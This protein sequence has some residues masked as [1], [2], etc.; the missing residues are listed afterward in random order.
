MSEGL[1]RLGDFELLRE[2][3]RGGMGVVYEARQV[4][5]NRPVALKLLPP[6]LG[7]TPQAVQRFQR[8]AQAAA[9]L[10]H[11]H[12][13]PVYAVGETDGSHYYAMELIDGQP[14][15]AIVRDLKGGG[16]NPLLDVAMTQTAGG[17]QV[18]ASE[19][20]A[21]GATTSSG[22]ATSLSDG[23]SGSR[24]WFEKIA[25]LVADVADV[26]EALHYAHG[27]GIV[28]RDIKP[29]NLLLASDGRL[30]VTDFG[31]AQV[32]QEPGMTVSGSFLGTPAYMSPEQ[33][34]VGR[35]KVDH[36][37]DIYSLGTVLYEMLTL[38]RPFPGEGREQILAGILTKEP[39]APRRIN[40]R[41]S[42]DLETICLK[43]IEKDPDR[44]YASAEAMAQDLR[45]YLG[46]GLIAARRTGVLRRSV[47][48][49][50]RRPVITTATVAVLLVVGVLAVAWRATSGQ[51]VESA[52]RS[53]ADAKL[54]MNQGE[55]RDA[56][57][58]VERALGVDD[59]LAEAHL[60]RARL[61]IKM[62]RAAEAVSEAQTLLERNPDE[63]TA[64][65]IM[66]AAARSQEG[67]VGVG[68]SVEEHVRAVEA[69]APD[70][71]DAHYLRSLVAETDTA[72]LLHLDRALE[73]DPGHADALFERSDRLSELHRFDEA[74][75]DC[76]RLIAV[77]PRS[78]RARLQKGRVYRHRQDPD[79][80]LVEVE[81][82]VALD[83]ENA[84]CLR[85]RGHLRARL[86]KHKEAVDDF[87]RAV[88]LDPN[89]WRCYL[90]R[91]QIYFG[92]GR[93]E[94][95]LADLERAV[96]AN[97]QQVD[98]YRGLVEF[99]QALGDADQARSALSVLEKVAATWTDPEARAGAHRALAEAYRSAGDTE[100]ALAEADR[101][102]AL[103]R[104]KWRSLLE[105]AHVQRL[106]GS[107][108]D[109]EADCASAAEVEIH[110]PHDIVD[111]GTMLARVC[112]RSDLALADFTRALEFDPAYVNLFRLR[113]DEYEHLGRFEESLAD[114]TKA[115][116]ASP[117][118]YWFR[119]YRGGTYDEMGL[120][121]EALADYDEGIRLAPDLAWPHIVRGWALLRMGRTSEALADLNKAV[122]LS[123]DWIG[124]RAD[125][126]LTLGR[127][128][129]AI[130]DMDKAIATFATPGGYA[131]RAYFLTYKPGACGRAAADLRQSE[132]MMAEEARDPGTLRDQAWVHVGGLY[133]AC[134]ELYDGKRALDLARR[135]VLL[136][137]RDKDGRGTLGIALY[138]NGR[139]DEAMKTLLTALPA[140]REDPDTL[141]FLA[142]AS[143]KLGNKAEA[144]RYYDR[145]VAWMKTHAPS[146]LKGRR[147]GDEAARVISAPGGGAK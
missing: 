12:I 80:A 75:A 91:G 59:G 82:A 117:R 81:R 30:C 73:L 121:K 106:R 10:H 142:M 50:R 58:H 88:A 124:S 134:P 47:K 37:T 76:D 65:L 101:A 118:Q 15:T 140:R 85:V 139:Y 122:E 127:V 26:A 11:T 143:H 69:G 28:H 13:V 112:D 6:G 32:A 107:T 84:A 120:V 72:A 41:I 144:R 78:A 147:I 86:G 16:S 98:P 108:S 113:A 7:L 57:E 103:D 119:L 141:L 61:L 131:N 109:F 95:G 104:E 42:Q 105:R 45:A 5:L 94:E 68:M 51:A 33:I 138:R 145:A 55:Y 77:R 133:Y 62:N 38:E 56:L 36:R 20:P 1:R 83:P 9:K 130:A 40:P 27:R 2:I 64:H 8:E 87:S 25:R 22:G 136:E 66:A 99:H 48:L 110:E 52:L 60:I 132:S 39:K 14:L 129:E 93:I 24:R 92:M 128:E 137:P 115:I 46:H 74:L 63:W 67:G 17:P 19:S 54:H 79:R 31:L 18:G 111:R 97:P 3:G 102:I 126:Y 100:R 146:D 114:R 23:S 44:R 71:A 34:A 29:A 35:I 89:D 96:A 43:A 53:L 90:E 135:A 21:S 116:D 123:P 125:A 49:V 4:S 70:T